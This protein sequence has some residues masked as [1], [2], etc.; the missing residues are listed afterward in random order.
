M[1]KDDSFRALG[2]LGPTSNDNA[3]K[4][5]CRRDS[6][7]CLRPTPRSKPKRAELFSSSKKNEQKIDGWRCFAILIQSNTLA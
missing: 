2:K 3:R 4:I 7:R 6:G 1:E 5:P